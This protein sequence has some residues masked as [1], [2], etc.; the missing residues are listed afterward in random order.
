MLK[1]QYAAAWQ[2]SWNINLTYPHS[3]TKDFLDEAIIK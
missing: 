1:T 2:R 3:D